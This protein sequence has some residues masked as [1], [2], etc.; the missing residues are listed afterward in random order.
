MLTESINKWGKREEEKDQALGTHSRGLPPRVDGSAAAWFNRNIKGTAD[1]I[2]KFLEAMLEKKFK[3]KQTFLVAQGLRL[4]LAMQGMWVWSLVRGLRSHMQQS[5]HAWVPHH[6]YWDHTAQLGSPCAT[7]KDRTWCNQD[8]ACHTQDPT[9][10]IN[11]FKKQKKTHT[12]E[13]NYLAH[14]IQ[15]SMTSTCSQY[16]NYWY[17]FP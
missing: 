14:Y 3:K 8:L 6:S 16:N 5:S 7:T 15:N 9:Q 1:A 13:S 2:S 17:S 11:I 12:D 4:C 10:L